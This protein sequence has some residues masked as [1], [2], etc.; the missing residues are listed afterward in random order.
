MVSKRNFIWNMI[1]SGIYAMATVLFVLIAKRVVGEEAGARFYMAFTTGQM[2]LT[3]GY[4]EIRPF[5]VTDV[6]GEYKPQEYFGFRVLTCALMMVVGL[7]VSVVYL[8][9]GRLNLAGITLII[10]MCIYKLSDGYSDVFEGEFQR[11][12]RIDI[13]G[14]AMAARTTAC[15]IAFFVVIYISKNIYLAS[16]ITALVGILGTVLV[17]KC[18]S[19]RYGKFMIVTDKQV[20]KSLFDNTLLIFISSAMCMWLWNGTKYVVEWNLSDTETLVYGILFMPNM[21]INLGSTFILKPMLTTLSRFYADGDRESFDKLITK[22]IMLIVGF[23]VICL[24]G[25]WLIG[26]PVLELMYAIELKSHT[27]VML[28]L[29]LAGGVNAVNVLLYY[30]LMVMRKQRSIFVGYG[31]SFAVSL[32]VPVLLVKAA[33]LMGAAFSY[34]IVM[35]VLMILFGSMIIERGKA[36]K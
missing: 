34:L 7:L 36:S 31:I 20:M 6:K 25:G 12:D 2:L 30:A 5:Q 15:L 1:G 32:V 14:K 29:I 10:S 26:I 21:V 23:T 8:V 13:S 27:I 11:N 28:I 35:A 9:S 18:W 4:F 3:I 33:G 17:G 22:L 16:A 19:R 24:L